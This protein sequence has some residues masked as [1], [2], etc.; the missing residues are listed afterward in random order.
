MRPRSVLLVGVLLLLSFGLQAFVL[1]THRVPVSSD[2]AVVG[3][4]ARHILAGKG[5]PVFY[6]GAA[7]AGSL[8]PHCVAAVFGLLGPSWASYRIAMALLLLLLALGVSLLARRAFGARAGIAALAYFAVPPFFLLYKGLTSDGAYDSVALAALATVAIAL[9]LDRPEGAQGR[10]GGFVLLGLV[11]GVGWWISPVTLPVSAAALLW[12]FWRRKD[13]PAPAAAL[14]AAVGGIAGSFPWWFWNLRHGWASLEAPEL[15]AVGPA[16]AARNLAR[17]LWTSLPALE[18]GMSATPDLRRLHETFPLSRSLALAALLV[19]LAPAVSAM[20]RGDRPKRLLGISLAGILL[21]AAFSRR[22]LASEPRYLIAYYAILPLLLAAALGDRSAGR[23]TRALR[24]AAGVLLLAVHLASVVTARVNFVNEDEE[25][26]G[27]LAPLIRFLEGRGIR[28][29]YA[30]YWTSYRLAF[31]SGERIVATP[32]SGDELV[33]YAPYQEEVDRASDPAV[34]LL[35]RRDACFGAFLS[36]KGIPF[37]RARVESFGVYTDLG[38]GAL[39]TLR[40]GLGLPL[41]SEAYRVAWR[42]GA[43]PAAMTARES[44]PMRVE[45]ENRGPCLWPASVHLGYHWRPLEAGGNEIY[46]GPRGYLPAPLRSG[47]W[48]AIPIELVAPASPGRYRLEYDLVHENVVWFS[49]AGGQTASVEV[50]VLPGPL[51]RRGP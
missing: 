26:T 4:M 3:L 25:V 14:A 43:Q 12:L 9:W 39:A 28:Y 50:R 19:L 22:L 47:E 2:Q 6:Y 13:R 49:G 46:D 33:R 29:A 51:E 27:S 20:R 11:V 34:A 35:D 30:N 8:E 15:G 5:H 17:I 7:Y 41:P 31:E 36:E 10:L 21:A 44:L 48:A 16:E 18:G 23:R 42:L 32:L 1:A 24:A 38:A 40:A 37:R 45:V